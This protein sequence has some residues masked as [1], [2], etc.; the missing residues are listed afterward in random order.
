M[1][2]QQLKLGLLTWSNFILLQIDTLKI[3][4]TS[5]IWQIVPM[6]IIIKGL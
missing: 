4:V 5:S 3:S 1:P 6:A 2:M